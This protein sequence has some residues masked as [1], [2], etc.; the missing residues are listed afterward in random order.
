MED[1]IDK[2][3]A[4]ADTL[5]VDDDHSVGLSACLQ[6]TKPRS[7]KVASHHDNNDNRSENLRDADLQ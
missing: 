3:V 1:F 6:G 5:T 4:L 7:R 2:V